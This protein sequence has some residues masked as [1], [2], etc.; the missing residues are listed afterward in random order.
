VLDTE[1]GQSSAHGKPGLAGPNDNRR[2]SK[3]PL[4][5]AVKPDTATAVNVW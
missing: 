1:L 4:S 2:H 5:D 3:P